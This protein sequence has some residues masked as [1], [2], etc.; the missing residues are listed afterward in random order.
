MAKSQSPSYLFPITIIGILFFIFGFITWANSQLIPYLKIA[1]QLTD[2]E[3]YF[4]GTAFFAA[5]FF[6]SIPSSYILK[7]A[8]F[9]KGMSI[10]LLIMAIGALLF[11]PAA[12]T[13]SYPLFLTGLFVIGTGL[14][15]LQTASNPYVTILGPIESAAQRISFMGVCNK[16]AGYCAVFLLSSLFLHNID[17]IEA[18]LPAMSAA[19]KALELQALANK[20][21][22][23]YSVISTSFALLGIMLLF[24]NLPEPEQ[25]KDEESKH[26]A[27]SVLGH[28]NLVL[29]A[30]ALFFYVG[31]EVISYDAFT[32]FGETLGYSKQIASKFAANT[33]IAMLVGYFLSIALIPKFI[34]QR[35]AL[36]ISALLS[37][38]FL[39]LALLTEGYT[40]VAFFA[41]LGL[42]QSAMWPI[43]WPLALNGLGKHTKIGSAILVMMIVGGAV[44]MP[45]MGLFA[46]WIDSKKIAFLIMVPGWLFL[47]YYA[48]SG[49]K[50]PY[51]DNEAV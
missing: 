19:D 20:V 43:I 49:Y 15:L 29:G 27:T 34:R 42:S 22:R 23:P 30:V 39:T 14:A 6:M 8:G 4:V 31:A 44:L 5:Y 1:C 28:R 45:L 13:I 41:L 51:G 36:I 37:I 12:R 50:T 40:A 47:I 16:L 2:T 7:W 38:L 25:D 32:T 17:Q 11:I 26:T 9:K 10:G 46:E 21:I 33:A 35:P 18:A 24:I 48:L 3:S